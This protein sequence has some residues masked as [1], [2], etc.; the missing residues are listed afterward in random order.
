MP[1]GRQPAGL[2]AAHESFKGGRQHLSVVAPQ[3]AMA[4]LLCSKKL[5]LKQAAKLTL[6]QAAVDRDKSTRLY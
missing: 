6:K 4:I 1:R 2:R 5:T 3:L